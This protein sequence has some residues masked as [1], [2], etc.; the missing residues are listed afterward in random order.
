MAQQ[1]PRI[2]IVL[3]SHDTL[4][5]T[6]KAT[7]FHYEE[8]AAPYWVF[9]DAGYTVD[10]ASIQ[11][12]EPPHDPSSLPD[13]P[14]E[15][16]GSV[17]RFRDDGEA[18]AKLR[19]TMRVGDLD[20]A[21]YAGIFLAG[22]HGAMWDFPD[23]ADLGRLLSSAHAQGRILGAVC[24]GPAG[25]IAAKRS[26]GSPLIKGVRLNAFT[27]AEEQ[28]VGLST[29]VPFLLESRLK[30]LGARFEKSSPF[31]GCAVHDQGFVTGQNPRSSR[32]VAERLLTVIAEAGTETAA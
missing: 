12:G 24:H 19:Q 13:T 30:E 3:T 20:P 31:R 14:A 5:D 17:A 22:G 2:A 9:V 1:D 29:V 10:I 18:C 16:P 28:Q 27:D 26:D 6:G 15:Q 7:G 4:G 21:A 11:G 8:L 23:N 25:L 32:A